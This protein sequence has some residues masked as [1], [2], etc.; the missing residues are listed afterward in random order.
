MIIVLL[1]FMS[2][3]KNIGGFNYSQ[4]LLIILNYS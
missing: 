1:L 4:Y 3:N 2:N